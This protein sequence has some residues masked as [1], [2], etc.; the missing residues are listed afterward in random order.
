MISR[1]S[2]KIAPSLLAITC[3]QSSSLHLFERAVTTSTQTAISAIGQ[4]LSRHD[5]KT[6]SRIFVAGIAFRNGGL[7]S[8]LYFAKAGML[9]TESYDKCYI[10]SVWAKHTHDKDPSM[11]QYSGQLF[12]TT[13]G[14]LITIPGVTR[15][16]RASDIASR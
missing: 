2:L 15:P 12:V 5:R 8:V 1:I 11:A 13:I 14:S 4:K 9:R 6:R 10:Y 16:I 3:R 7:M